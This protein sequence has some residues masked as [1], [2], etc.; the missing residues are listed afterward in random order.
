MQHPPLP[1]IPLHRK[2]Y[3]RSDGHF[4]FTFLDNAS[5]GV[6]AKHNVVAGDY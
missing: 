3:G 1:P 6:A 2:S 4:D 5:E